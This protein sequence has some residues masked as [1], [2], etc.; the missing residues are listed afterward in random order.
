MVVGLQMEKAEMAINIPESLQVTYDEAMD[1]LF[2]SEMTSEDCDIEYPPKKEA[3]TNCLPGPMGSGGNV[4][5]NGGPAPFSFGLCPLCQGK[6]FKETA[7]TESVRLRVHFVS[8]NSKQKA[9]KK[10]ANINIED[11]EAQIIGYMSDLTK[12][13]RAE[14]IILVTQNKGNHKI[15]CRLISEPI[16]WGFGRG[17]YFSA[18]VGKE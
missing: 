14:S 10:I 1:A 12:I 8:D 11:Y 3:C 6:G 2:T 16:P 9:Y 13:K 15:K 5:R 18:Y 17:R 7:A 4:Y